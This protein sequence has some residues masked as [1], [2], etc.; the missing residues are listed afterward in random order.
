MG[1]PIKPSRNLVFCYA[2]KKRKCWQESNCFLP[3]E[4][5]IVQ[6]KG[7]RLSGQCPFLVKNA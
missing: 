7:L 1:K 4:I 3:Q 6:L 5:G 2:C